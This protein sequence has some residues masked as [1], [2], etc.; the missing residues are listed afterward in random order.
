M[1]SRARKTSTM[2]R[3]SLGDLV[4]EHRRR[5]WTCVSRAVRSVLRSRECGWARLRGRELPYVWVHMQDAEGQDRLDEEEL[6]SQPISFAVHKPKQAQKIAR[7]CK[8]YS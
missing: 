2:A 7:G 1:A 3:R 4:L 5:N 8:D 6:M